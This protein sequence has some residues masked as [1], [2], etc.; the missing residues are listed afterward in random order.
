MFLIDVYQIDSIQNDHQFLCPYLWQCIEEL[1]K[2]GHNLD[3][4]DKV[5]FGCTWKY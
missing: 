2:C 1:S 4:N 3:F 5:I